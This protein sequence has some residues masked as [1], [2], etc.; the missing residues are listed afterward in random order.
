MEEAEP[1]TPDYAKRREG[2]K[3]NKFVKFFIHGLSF[4]LMMYVIIIGW[5]FILIP[6]AMCGFCFG[7][8]IALG[9]LAYAI[10]WINSWLMERVW[11]REKEEFDW[12]GPLIHGILLFV[13]ILVLSIPWYA[14]VL[15]FPEVNDWPYLIISIVVFFA[16]C[17]IDGFAAYYVG[18]MFTEQFARIQPPIEPPVPASNSM[19]NEPHGPSPPNP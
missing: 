9:I 18:T 2:L 12:W 6:F 13:V 14:V 3:T 19:A 15:A 16:Y 4:T 5:I 1:Y 17:L 10:G 8:A 7:V 11:G